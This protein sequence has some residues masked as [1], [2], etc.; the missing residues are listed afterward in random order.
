MSLEEKNHKIANLKSKLIF[1]IEH[2]IDLEKLQ[3]LE[4]LISNDKMDEIN[5][6]LLKKLSKPMRKSINLESLKKEQNY[7]AIS[8]DELKTKLKEFHNENISQEQL[9]KELEHLD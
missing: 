3:Q 2:L 9:R 1:E 5:T 7:N 8:Y 6:D 4:K